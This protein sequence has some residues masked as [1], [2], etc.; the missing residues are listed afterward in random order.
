[1]KHKNSLNYQGCHKQQKKIRFCTL[2]DFQNNRSNVSEKKKK[3]TKLI[4]AMWY[5]FCKI[6]FKIYGI[7]NYIEL[8]S[9]LCFLQD[10]CIITKVNKKLIILI[11]LGKEKRYEFLKICSFSGDKFELTDKDMA[12]NYVLFDYVVLKQLI[13]YT[14]RDLSKYAICRLYTKLPILHIRKRMQEKLG[15]L[16]WFLILVWPCIIWLSFFS[17]FVLTFR[18]RKIL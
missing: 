14:V 9:C 11:T 13:Q 17:I 15:E 6:I 3:T 1:M 7:F 18:S 12:L 10:E 16:C 5:N 4:S 8:Y 2:Y